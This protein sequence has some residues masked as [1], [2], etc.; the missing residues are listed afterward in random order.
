MTKTLLC[1][2]LND[3]LVNSGIYNNKQE[4]QKSFCEYIEGMI[5]DC[6]DLD[7]LYLSGKDD[8]SYDVK[9]IVVHED[10]EFVCFVSSMIES[11]C[12]YTIVCVNEGWGLYS[13]ADKKLY[14]YTTNIKVRE[15]WERTAL[16]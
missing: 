5:E 11:A 1:V 15:Q 4:A 3:V 7:Y 14:G 10:K 9:G 16:Q 12:L 13:R 8:D 6:S 2:F